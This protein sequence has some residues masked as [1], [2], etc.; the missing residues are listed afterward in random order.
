MSNNFYRLVDIVLHFLPVKRNWVMMTSFWGMYNDNPK[1]ISQEL[2]RKNKDIRIFWGINTKKS[3]ETIPE[4]VKAVEY[5][6]L[7]YYW[8]KNRCRVVI[9]NI[10]GD[11]SMMGD[12][13]QRSCKSLLK[14]KKQFNLSTWHGN[15]IKR[16]G[17]DLFPGQYPNDKDFFSTSDLLIC[18]CQY[19]NDIFIKCFRG[20]PKIKMTGTPRVDAMF[21]KDSNYLHLYEK[22]GIP[23]GKKVLL[24]APTYRNNADDSGI[25]QI[26]NLDLQVLLRTISEKFGGDWVFVFR[27]HN[28]A[29]DKLRHNGVFDS[30]NVINGNQGDDMMEYM[31]IADAMI[32]DY[33]GAIFDYT[34]TY[35]P[36]FLYAHDLEHY[37]KIERGTYMDIK[38]LPYPFSET[39]DDLYDSIRNYN[40]IEQKKCIQDFNARIGNVEDGKA[41]SRVADIILKKIGT[42]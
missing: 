5:N 41:S 28:S 27:V 4:Y 12:N 40:P 23:N 31:M 20:G 25:I 15:P 19:V 32:C 6:T 24:Y 33:S 34:H 39:P 21:V 9:D 37:T 14:N 11:Y 17:R 3:R 13:V 1:Y 18:G 30:P 2:H 42:F 10:V 7:S 22:L 16:I 8:Y 29:L 38:D 35:R 36:C 26:Q